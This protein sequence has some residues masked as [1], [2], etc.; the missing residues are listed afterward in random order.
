MISPASTEGTLINLMIKRW[1]GKVCA[2]TR[3][4]AEK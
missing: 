3:A 4:F 1:H 2:R